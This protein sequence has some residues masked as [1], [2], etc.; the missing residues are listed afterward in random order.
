MP[1]PNASAKP[2]TWRV[3]FLTIVATIIALVVLFF[4]V[5]IM[6]TRSGSDNG[7]TSY[8][9]S[10]TAYDIPLTES[11]MV[12]GAMPRT[13]AA[14]S[15]I[16][17]ADNSTAA[18]RASVGPKIIRTGSLYLQVDN[19]ERRL[20]EAKGL[21][22]KH[23]G[24]VASVSLEDDEGVRSADITLRVPSAAYDT[25]V[26][27]AKNLAVIVFS[28]DSNAEDVTETFVDIQARLNAAKA[29]ETQYLNILKQAKNVEET[30]KVTSALSDVRSR[31]ERL[32]GQIRYLSDRTDFATLRLILTEET[33]IEIPTRT[34]APLETVRQVFRSLV[35]ALQY[36]VDLLI[37]IAFYG[38]GLILPAVLIGWGIWKLV[39]MVVRRIRRRNR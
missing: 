37:V 33:R 3:V 6:L 4:I 27:D 25:L 35:L 36:F 7:S 26:A 39:A 18:D 16:T 11:A 19:T 2:R 5:A 34:W 30:L 28:E 29:E 1:N 9:G 8:S 12:S 38:I 21:A 24:F 23:G 17:A 10:K 22:A 31:I 13:A 14:P 15:A 20:E 32:Q